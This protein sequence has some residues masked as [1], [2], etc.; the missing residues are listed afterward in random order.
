[1]DETDLDIVD[2]INA[3]LPGEKHLPGMLY[4]GPGTRLDLKVNEDGTPKPGFEPV[5]R[6]DRAALRH[7]LA[8]SRHSDLRNRNVA[9]KVMI[10]ELLSIPSP[11]CRERCER[12]LVIP[13]MCVKRAVGSIILAI[14]DL[15]G[16]E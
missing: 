5:D 12:C 16:R 1:M 9:D 2:I 6:V 14:M 11:T 13:I 4:C 8:Y 3:A 15:F 10:K 7:D